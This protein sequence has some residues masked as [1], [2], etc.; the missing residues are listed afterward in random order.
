MPTLCL[1]FFSMASITRQA[2]SSM[3]EIVQQDY[4]RTAWA[5]GLRE[6]V[7]ILRHAIKNAFIPVVT[8]MGT[9]IGIIFGGS[10]L[11]E[12]VFSIPGMGRMMTEAVFGQDYQVVQAGVLI[13]SLVVVTVNLVVDISSVSEGGKVVAVYPE[14][15][16]LYSD[17]PFCILDAEWIT[18]KQR[19]VAEEFLEFL[20]E[21]DTVESAMEYGF[22]P[23]DTSIKLD[24]DVFNYD[25]NGISYNLTMNRSNQ[26]DYDY[27]LIF[28]DAWQTGTYSFTIWLMDYAGNSN[29]SGA[30][31]DFV[32][33]SMFGNPYIGY[34]DQLLLDRIAGSVFQIHEK[35]I[36][37]YNRST[38]QTSR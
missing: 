21:R 14:E 22:R 8:V 16:T 1:S 3:L 6:R 38:Y 9:H 30:T 28:S 24:P 19:K 36:V 31:F 17:H 18:S 32:I 4:I 12:T 23:I 10:V 2:R 20:Q 5:K 15:G 25:D 11:I 7:I 27:E 26:T 37:D 34:R 13:I 35:G 29:T 33:N